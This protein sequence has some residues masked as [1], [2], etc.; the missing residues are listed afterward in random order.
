VASPSMP[1]GQIL[2][3][4]EGPEK[5]GRAA[6]DAPTSLFRLPES[7]SRNDIELL[8]DNL[9]EPIDVDLDLANRTIY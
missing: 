2:L 1:T 3:D 6:F 8:Y 4:P 5:V 7:A 9:P